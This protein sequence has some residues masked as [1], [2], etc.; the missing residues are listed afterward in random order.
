MAKENKFVE[1]VNNDLATQ[2]SSLIQIVNESPV[3]LEIITRT[4]LLDIENYYIGAG[5]IAQTVWNHYSGYSP[6]HG[7]SDVDLVYFDNSDLSIEAENG[8]IVKVEA[9]FRDI[10]I[11]M[12]VKNQARVHIWYEQHFGYPIPPYKSLEAAVNTWPTTATAIGIR[13]ERDEWHVYAPYGLNDLFGK[14]V[15]ANK[16]QITKE[17][18]DKKVQR[19][20]GIWTDLKVIPW[21]E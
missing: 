18:Y 10:P 14:I 5:C 3:L 4:P 13:R 8:F 7:I 6:E 1:A 15:R 16:L 19:W 20:S 2:I 21:D 9:A 12:D 17:I 11:R